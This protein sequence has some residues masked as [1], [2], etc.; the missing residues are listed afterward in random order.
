MRYQTRVRRTA[1]RRPHSRCRSTTTATAA[2]KNAWEAS[3]SSAGTVAGTAVGGR[4]V[5]RKARVSNVLPAVAQ[6]RPWRCRAGPRRHRHA[7]PALA[8]RPRPTRAYVR[9]GTNGR[10]SAVRTSRSSGGSGSTPSGGAAV[11]STTTVT[12]T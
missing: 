5:D 9:T 3:I 6:P 10:T 11:A 2:G 1:S 8:S 4:S 7:T 12:A